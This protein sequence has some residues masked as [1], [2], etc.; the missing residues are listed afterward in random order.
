MKKNDIKPRKLIF[1]KEGLQ[2]LAKRL[3]EIRAEKGL[4][5]EELA[6]RSEITLSQIARIETVKINP[7]VS[8][9]FKIARA[10]EVPL[11]DLFNFELPPFSNE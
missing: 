9:I 2:L 8:T 3:K 5:Q 7:T 1:D 4:S 11:S 6:Y 10:L